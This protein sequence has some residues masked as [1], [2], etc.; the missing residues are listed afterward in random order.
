MPIL[1]GALPMLGTYFGTLLS[2]T[3]QSEPWV[4]YRL[5][6]DHN[7]H[8]FLFHPFFEQETVFAAARTPSPPD[9]LQVE[10]PRKCWRHGRCAFSGWGP[11]RRSRGSRLV[12]NETRGPSILM[13]ASIDI[14]PNEEVVRLRGRDMVAVSTS[15]SMTE[16]PRAVACEHTH[17]KKLDGSTTENDKKKNI[18]GVQ[19]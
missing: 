19:K 5:A 17:H 4:A 7:E 3:Y 9:A 15:R 10:T 2:T 13:I 6:R 14:M 12:L 8:P 18:R 1:Y 11:A 16:L